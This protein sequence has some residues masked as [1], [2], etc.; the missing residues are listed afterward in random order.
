MELNKI[1][2]AQSYISE[3]TVEEKREN[4]DYTIYV[5]LIDDDGDGMIPMLVDGNHSYEAAKRDGVDP[6]IEIIEGHHQNM[7]LE[8]Y[9]TSMNDLSNPV[10]IVTGRDL[11]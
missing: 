8:E 5:E 9:V 10:N 6:T 1:Y 7:T 4:K 11:W 2:T 3:E